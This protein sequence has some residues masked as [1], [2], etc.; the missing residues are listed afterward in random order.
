ME[1]KKGTFIVIDGPDSV[2]KS[3]QVEILMERLLKE[4][5]KAVL[6]DF[7]CYKENFFGKFIYELLH[8]PMFRWVKIHPKIASIVYALD[9]WETSPRLHKAMNEGY[10]VIANR[11]TS[12]NQIHQGGKIKDE[13]KRVEFIEWLNELEFEVLK[14]PRPDIVFCLNVTPPF[15]KM[16]L[17][18]RSRKGLFGKIKDVHERSSRFIKNSYACSLW[19]SATQPGWVTIDCVKDKNLRTPEDIN[20][21]IYKK[22]MLF[23]HK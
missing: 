13:K 23:I 10:L 11:Y 2:G 4:G 19:L 14:I 6:A 22:L 5:Y 1:T 12:S 18:K 15:G 8:N 21:E 9:R 3:T 7:P 16:L 17:K 20:E